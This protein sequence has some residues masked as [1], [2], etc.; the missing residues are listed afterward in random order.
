MGQGSQKEGK[1]LADSCTVA[2]R[3]QNVILLLTYRLSELKLK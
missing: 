2:C 1:Y 3:L